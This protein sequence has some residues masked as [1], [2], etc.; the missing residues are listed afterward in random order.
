MNP[1]ITVDQVLGTETREL[2]RRK[3]GTIEVAL[4]WQRTLKRVELCVQDPATGASFRIEVAPDHA[5]EAFYHP[6]AYAATC[7]K[8]R[9][10][11]R[12]E[13]TILDG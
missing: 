11:D 7:R 9:R 2:A 8:C 4:L 12:E 5:L 3:N 10:L 1:T 6:Y 13:T